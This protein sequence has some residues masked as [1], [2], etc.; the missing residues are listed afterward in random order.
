MDVVSGRISQNAPLIA[1]AASRYL[2]RSWDFMGSSLEEAL[3]VMGVVG[4][5][6]G[7]RHDGHHLW[8][9]LVEHD[10]ARGLG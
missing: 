5:V 2:A 3:E 10:H 7:W 1:S 4:G 8:A 6:T 9:S